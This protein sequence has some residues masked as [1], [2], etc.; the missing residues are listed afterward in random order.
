MSMLD[1]SL[2]LMESPAGV[3]GVVE[4]NT[5]LF[6]RET[7]EAF[8]VHFGVVVASWVTDPDRTLARTEVMTDAERRLL[9]DW[10]DTAAEIPD[11]CLHELIE[12]Q[13]AAT[14]Q[15]VAV[16]SGEASLRYGELNA[17]ANQLAHHLAGLRVRPGS[18][19]GL[20][21]DRGLDMV[22]GILAILKAGAAYVPIDAL[23]HPPERIAFVLRDAAVATMVAHRDLVDRLP[24]DLA[25]LVC[26]DD[27]DQAAVIA[28]AP[29]TNRPAAS[30]PA[31]SRT[32]S[33]PS[34]PPAPPRASWSNTAPPPT[35]GR[36]SG[37]CW[38][39][40]DRVIAC[41]SSLR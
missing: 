23:L 32:S 19:V 11:G 17:R 27:P 14:P 4:F 26:L 7:I 18:L 10:N 16:V 13:V 3:E 22:V 40:S 5:D 29:V 2:A 9:E 8:V 31:T 24:G 38:P 20:C 34:A 28:R 39:I 41:C 25:Q 36:R 15:A 21:V 30:P 1:V 12:S 6:D 35:S 37:R 33:T